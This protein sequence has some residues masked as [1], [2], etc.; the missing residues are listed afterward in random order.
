MFGYN[1]KI[2]TM[3]HLYLNLREKDALW[4]EAFFKKLQHESEIP[5]AYLPNT[6]GFEFYEG[7]PYHGW[8]NLPEEWAELI[9][10]LPLVKKYEDPEKT[11]YALNVKTLNRVFVAWALLT[12]R[13]TKVWIYDDGSIH[14][15]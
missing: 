4:R 3:A 8:D 5:Y 14:C 11:W 13:S 6:E 15:N 10:F 2:D 7:A 9:T 1:D 12:Q